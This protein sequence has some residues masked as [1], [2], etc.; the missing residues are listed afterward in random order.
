MEGPGTSLFQG[1]ESL[2]LDPNKEREEEEEALQDQKRRDEELRNLLTNAFDDL[3]E[4]DEDDASSV[5]SSYRIPN[6]SHDQGHGRFANA[7][8]IIFKHMVSQTSNQPPYSFNNDGSENVGMSNQEYPT[9]ENSRLMNGQY[10]G[11]GDI[12]VSSHYRHCYRTSPGGYIVDNDVRHTPDQNELYRQTSYN[13][14]EQLEVL[15]S[16]RVREVQRLTQQL[17]EFSNEA[18]K[19]REEMFSKLAFWEAEQ[20]RA[21]SLHKVAEQ[22]LFDSKKKISEFEKEVDTLKLNINNLEKSNAHL[23]QEI[24]IC[25]VSMLDLQQKNLLLERGSFNSTEKHVDTFMKNVSKKHE[26]ELNDIQNKLDTTT[27]KLSLKES[28]FCQLEQ[29]VCELIRAQ[30]ALQVEKGETINHLSRSLEESQRQCQQLM[31]S[32]ASQETIGLKLQLSTTR[33]EKDELSKKVHT[34]T[35]EVESLRFDLNQ[36][37]NATHLGLINGEDPL[38]TDSVINLGIGKMSSSGDGTKITKNDQSNLT[39]QLRDEYYRSLIGQKLKREEIRRLKSQLENKDKII[40]KLK[41]DETNY[42]AQ[43]EKFKQDATNFLTQLSKQEEFSKQMENLSK[44]NRNLCERLEQ[45]GGEL[46]KLTTQLE[47]V[48]KE[49]GVLEMENEQL[50]ERIHELVQTLDNEK[51]STIE[52]YNKEYFKF[53]DEALTRV[54]QEKHEQAE[55]QVIDLS[56]ANSPLWDGIDFTVHL[57]GILPMVGKSPYPKTP[58]LTKL[59]ADV[60]VVVQGTNLSFDDPDLIEMQLEQAGKECE[61]VKR[62]YIDICGSKEKL[63]HQLELE[64]K[65]VN[66]LSSQL[67]TETDK[68]NKV[69]KELKEGQEASR[70]LEEQ[71][72]SEQELVKHLKDSLETERI[73]SEE[74]RSRIKELEK[75]KDEATKNANERA[76]L[77]Y[78]S[79]VNEEIDKAKREALIEL[80]NDCQKRQEQHSSQV[81]ELEAEIKNLRSIHAEAERS[82]QQLLELTA[83]LHQ[84]EGV[85]LELRQKKNAVPEHIFKMDNSR[86]PSRDACTSPIKSTS[87]AL[88]DARRECARG[89]AEKL[90][91][92]E[93][94]H[95]IELDEMQEKIKDETVN[96]F[97]EEIRKMET[98]H[99][100][101]LEQYQSAAG[102][103]LYSLQNLI[104]SKASENSQTCVVISSYYLATKGL[105][106]R[107]G[108]LDG[109]RISAA[110]TSSW[111]Q[112]ST[113][114]ISCTSLPDTFTEA[115][116]RLG[117]A[118]RSTSSSEPSILPQKKESP[119]RG[120]R[121]SPPQERISPSPIS[122]PLDL[123]QETRQPLK[124]RQ[125]W[126]RKCEVLSTGLI[127]VI[128]ASVAT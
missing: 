5:N 48:R 44:E 107:G 121:A 116:H 71:L 104:E 41:D 50:K 15:Y 124:S 63:T 64:Q 77:L 53:H 76:R 61:E 103:Q 68:L 91:I 37:E 123:L 108:I 29:R 14:V 33:Q 58:R 89:Y 99:R 7:D 31:S 13:S 92:L 11:E 62:L 17:E 69:L 70:T 28:Q 98:K 102:K 75:E 43:A 21:K 67:N 126:R 46:S 56:T 122:Q 117:E 74:L 97:A 4:E 6:T 40:K 24:E 30:E 27:A 1:S 59:T 10:T 88:E 72:K 23:T 120:K 96:F 9:Y 128:L 51:V 82:R 32:A 20:E 79:K 2:H 87:D 109:N 95:R 112:L 84:Q 101:A 12:N 52:Q 100:A 73:N 90:A 45:S 78:T 111:T 127:E 113:W 16:V 81:S 94:K 118:F 105:V 85:I 35:K 55:A 119:T 65:A 125:E 36:Y 93:S 80:E 83:R 115:L 18:A 57:E 110:I 3:I 38:S 106:E 86:E 22:Q 60:P 39:A 49:K 42:L 114:T 26:Q 66:N 25:R 47:D 54:R 34:L 19:E 8:S